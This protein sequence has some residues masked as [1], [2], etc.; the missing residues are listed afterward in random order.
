MC[1]SERFVRTFHFYIIITKASIQ[2]RHSPVYIFIVIYAIIKSVL[3]VVIIFAFITNTLNIYLTFQ[4]S[5]L[6]SGLL[7][8]GQELKEH[9]INSRASLNS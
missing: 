7:F 9:K 1:V 6:T 2:F 8:V 5:V 3:H 4:F